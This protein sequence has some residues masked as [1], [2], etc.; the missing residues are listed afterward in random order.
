MS[1]GA[2]LAARIRREGDLWGRVRLYWEIA[3]SGY[4]RYAAYRGATYAGVFTNTVFGFMRAY[5]LIALFRS[6][7]HVGGY[8]VA[9]VLTYTWLTQ[10]S[11][12]AVFIWGWFEIALR[13]RSGDVA[14]DL[15]RPVDFQAYWLT[16]DLGRALYH[17]IY[18]GIPP[19]LIGA[20]VFRLFLP[21]DPATYLLYAV[22]MVLAVCIS[23]SFRF[24]TNIL[25][26][27]L[28]DYRGVMTVAASFWT[29]LSGFVVPLAI[30]PPAWRAVA[31]ALPFAGMIQTPIDIFLE[32]Y[33]G[34]ALLAVLGR[35]LLWALALLALGRWL[36]ALA[37]RKL[38]V[39]GG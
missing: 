5:V 7:P 36:M 4:R 9:D 6:H 16:Q 17:T 28:L 34:L 30:F 37:M 20:L 29:F 14:S 10:A 12:A 32:K 8:T 19:F 18:R 13:I 25:A 39:Q 3:R 1:G 2:A 26:F 27:W 35:Q 11:L 22:S 21:L 23:F 31:E 33:Q 15:Q 38:V 24:M